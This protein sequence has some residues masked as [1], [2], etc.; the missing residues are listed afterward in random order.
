[1]TPHC[2]SECS[3]KTKLSTGSSS[4]SLATHTALRERK[5]TAFTTPP[6]TGEGRE[7][8]MGQDR[9]DIEGRKSRRERSKRIEGEKER[10]NRG[11]G[12]QLVGQFM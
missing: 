4:P 11:K 12:F 6:Y 1:M 7:R 2:E 8:R 9:R 3:A 10:D 5:D